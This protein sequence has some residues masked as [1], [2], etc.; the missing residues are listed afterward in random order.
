MPAPLRKTG[1]ALGWSDSGQIVIH[2]LSPKGLA[3]RHV[4]AVGM[5]GSDESLDHQLSADGLHI[6]LPPKPAGE[7][8]YVFRIGLDG[9]AQSDPK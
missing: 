4:R 1:I 7:N 9:Q 2:T 8:A 5:L 6:K 3:D